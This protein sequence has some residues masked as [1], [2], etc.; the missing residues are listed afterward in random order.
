MEP[1]PDEQGTPVAAVRLGCKENGIEQLFD[2]ALSDLKHKSARRTESTDGDADKS[3]SRRKESR[4][5]KQSRLDKRKT[6]YAQSKKQKENA[7]RIKQE[8][9][10]AV[11]LQNLKAQTMAANAAAAIVAISASQC[12]Q[13]GSFLSMYLN[14]ALIWRLRPLLCQPLQNTVFGDRKCAPG[15]SPRDSICF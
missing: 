14:I 9:G 10:R 2:Q 7:K 4:K 11:N 6:E 5:D 13:F 12:Q 8:E 1:T 3:L 15:A